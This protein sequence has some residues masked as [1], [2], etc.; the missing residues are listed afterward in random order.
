MAVVLLAAAQVAIQESLSIRLG[1]FPTTVL[2]FG[3]YVLW[4]KIDNKLFNVTGP[5]I[6]E[7]FARFLRT[8]AILFLVFYG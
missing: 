6:R 5:T 7:M 1:A 3:T 2:A 4:R 8:M